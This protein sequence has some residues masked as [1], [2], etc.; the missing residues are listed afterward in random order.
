MVWRNGHGR[1]RR[2]TPPGDSEI[3]KQLPSLIV[4]LLLGAAAG[5]ATPETSAVW[6]DDL[7]IQAHS[8][9][10][11]PVQAK[12][13]YTH[14]TMRMDGT[15]HARGVGV[16][17]VS[18]LS[19]YL[20]G[21]AARFTALVGMDDT[22]NR[23]VPVTFYVIA[24]RKILFDSGRMR[25]GDAPKPVDVDLAGVRQ[26][27][28]LVT[29]KVGGVRN[30]RTYSNWADAQ[31]IM[32]G[33]RM[34]VPRPNTGEKHILTPP[35]PPTPRIN[36]ARVFG[37]TPGRP[38]LYTIAATGR[39]P[40]RFSAENLPPGLMLDNATGII[41]GSVAERGV[42]TV[43]I[44]AANDLGACAQTL[45]I[46]IGDAIALT[47]PMGWNGWN[48]WAGAIDREKVLASA[49]AMVASGLV[50]Y[51]WTYI[52]IDDTWQGTRGG[53][54]TALQPNGKFPNFKEMADRIHAMGLKIGV[55]STPYIA[56][57]AGYL[58]AS[59][60]YPEGGERHGDIQGQSFHRIGK[61]R[62]EANDARQMAEWGVDFLKYDWRMDVDSARRMSDALRRS[63]RDIVLSLSNN[64]PIRKA[65]HW[66]R[67][68]NMYRTGPD[69][70]DSWTSLY[71]TSFTID[72]WLPH[73]G[74]G[75]WGDPDM[76]VLGNV[77][78]GQE[79][80]PTRLT[81]DE[82]YSHMS[83][84][85]LIAAPL[86]IGCPLEQLDAFTLGLLTNAE[87]IGVNQD[88]LGRPGRL[89]AEKDGVQVWR[90]P[91][92]DGSQAVGLF[93]VGGFGK[94]PESYFRWG[95]EAAKSFEFNFAKLGMKGTWTL[96]DLWR[97]KDLGAFNG[98]FKTS[99]PHHGVVLLRMSK[100]P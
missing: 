9:G 19:F 92:E 70:R 33:G 50:N 77:T 46:K 30:N 49:E 64:A 23:S 81:P 15:S 26:L 55:Y 7:E 60:D 34:P 93:N 80:H 29:D 13:N 5:H 90:K 6:L 84:F 89:V 42:H 4:I 44:K 36:S 61:H 58:G 24:D 56:S 87:V 21:N 88:P 91:M 74:P 35:A 95:D 94:T 14:D 99:I 22:A 82:Q 8:E 67:A 62:F 28:L 11:R 47:P 10:I 16:Q 66:A 51:G 83:L 71:L 63:G 32:V 85:C 2:R 1:N 73:T 40:M 38:F 52:N 65:R 86:L 45:T 27:G 59:S 79:M 48:S 18:V 17:S 75:H 78:T 100:T 57:Y 96:R 68:A 25:V 53:P 39:R 54:L 37:A 69:I 3:K 43:K 97:Q 12:A 41:T 20:D 72:K 76:M 31:L 98:S